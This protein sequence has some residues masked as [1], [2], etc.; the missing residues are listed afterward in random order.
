M[1]GFRYGLRAVFLCLMMALAFSKPATAQSAPP[2]SAGTPVPM[3]FAQRLDVVTRQQMVSSNSPWMAY[4]LTSAANGTGIENNGTASCYAYLY[5][6]NPNYA[7]QAW[8]QIKSWAVSGMLPAGNNDNSLRIYTGLYAICYR[9]LRPTL[10]AA[11]QQLY[12]T[13]MN[14]V[15]NRARISF[16]SGNANGLIGTYLGLCLWSLI[17]APDQPAVA[18]GFLS[19]TWKDSGVVKPYGGLDYDPT[20]GPRGS[21]RNAIYD[22]VSRSLSPDKDT[23]VW[24]EG[25]QYFNASLEPLLLYT[26]AIDEITGVEHF[27]EVTA[28][29]PAMAKGAIG[30]LT[31]NLTQEFQFGDD[32]F[33]PSL[34]DSLHLSDTICTTSILSRRLVGTTI[35][36]QL[37][38]L[39]NTW[40]AIYGKSGIACRMYLAMDP[41][42]ATSDFRSVHWP[43]NG[44]GLSVWRSGWDD[45]SDSVFGVN[46]DPESGVN[47]TGPDE[48]FRSFRLYRKGEWALQ[49]PIT[50]GGMGVYPDGN[51]TVVPF[52][53][54]VQF[55]HGVTAVEDGTNYCYQRSETAGPPYVA[56]TYKPPI[57]YVAEQC[58]SVLYVHGVNKAADVIVVADRVNATTP[59]L[60]GW[61]PF[62][63]ARI[64]AAEE[65]DFPAGPLQ[66]TLHMPVS[67][68]VQNGTIWW[69]TT[70][71]QNV[72]AAELDGNASSFETVNEAATDSSGNYQ[73]FNYGSVPASERKW[74]VRETIADG[75][76][77]HFLLHAIA[78]FDGAIAP[79]MQRIDGAGVTGALVQPAGEAAT[80]AVFGSDPSVRQIEGSYSLSFASGAKETDVYLMDIDP[81]KT[82]QIVRDGGQPVAASFGP[83][84]VVRT[85][86]FG[87]GKH[88]LQVLVN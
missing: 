57:P 72:F 81:S 82:V 22:Y 55:A 10:S 32:E 42:A 34:S 64:T 28:A 63:L 15:A 56:G 35:G 78:V 6:G 47:H 48:V 77:W 11:D 53:K 68:M 7:S 87:Q 83:G 54:G 50:Y 71:G 2:P 33:P 38:W 88:S 75:Q 25:T 24:C 46:T 30:I 12:L 20:L 79:A 43:V 66:W 26:L 62:D 65:S 40:T 27:P 5:T 80:L 17:S 51:N 52:G 69:Q 67:P 39:V 49:H 76:P 70:G 21:A 18:A 4:L 61:R 31:N 16:F 36:A 41:Y 19:G 44:S 37:Q 86:F 9:I 8:S 73:Y 3:P 58:G 1:N 23:F 13:W 59:A 29:M 74:Q 85:A 84:G 60:L 45:T 14:G